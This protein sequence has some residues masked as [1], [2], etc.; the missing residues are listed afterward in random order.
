MKIFYNI[1]LK[2]FHWLYSTEKMSSFSIQVCNLLSNIYLLE[3]QYK[4]I[5]RLISDIY[6]K[7]YKQYRNTSI[8]V[9]YCIKYVLNK[10]FQSFYSVRKIRVKES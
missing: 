6:S 2:K 9:P 3:S 5:K 10:P 8:V 4:S 7:I 1:F